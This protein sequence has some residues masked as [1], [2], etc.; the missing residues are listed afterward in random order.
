[1]LPPTSAILSSV[2]GLAGSET[3]QIFPFPPRRVHLAHLGLQGPQAL[4]GLLST[5][6]T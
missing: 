5:T 6:A 2:G 1:M 4:P 3:D